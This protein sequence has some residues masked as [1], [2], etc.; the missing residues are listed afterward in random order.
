MAEEELDSGQEEEDSEE[1]EVTFSAME[2]SVSSFLAVPLFLP[3]V[4]S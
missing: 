4:A 3:L 2:D 1:E